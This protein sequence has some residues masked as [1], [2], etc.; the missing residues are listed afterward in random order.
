MKE[1]F[2]KRVYDSWE[3]RDGYRILIDRVWP[4]GI[5]KGKAHLDEWAKAITP[6]SELRKSVHA[7]EIS[8]EEFDKDYEKELKGNLDF[9][10]FKKVVLEK[11][12][13]KNVTLITSAH[14]IAG[15][16]PYV[17]KK[18]LKEK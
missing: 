17:L 1:I 7:G 9:T 15:G 5:S 18:L 2:I 16:H 4:R 3:E 6:S 14:L 12:E 11:L 10:S 13:R 8:W